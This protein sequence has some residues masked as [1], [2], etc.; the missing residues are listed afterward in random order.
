MKLLNGILKCTII[1]VFTSLLSCNGGIGGKK[2]KVGFLIR[3]FVIDRCAIERDFFVERMNQL[4]GEAIIA[5][6]GE[7][8]KIQVGQGRELLDKDIDVLVIFPVNNSSSAEIVRAANAK[9]VPVIAYE[10]LIENCNLDYFISAD[11]KKAGNIMAQHLVNQ[12][13][14]GNYVIIGGDRFDKNAISIKEGNY[15]VINPLIKSGNINVMYDIFSNWTADDAYIEIK[16][17]LDLTGTNPDAILCSN[18]GM[19]RGIIKA[20]DEYGL[21]GKIPVTGLDADLSAC[22]YIAQGKQFL[23]IYKSFKQ[24]AYTATEMAY[25]IAQGH[26]PKQLNAEV[27]NGRVNVA[28]YLIT[29][30]VVDKNNLKEIIIDNKV[31]SADQVY[32]N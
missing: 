21:A 25:E 22:R 3:G 23:T 28:S 27:F 17:V 32:G 2:V 1:I 18:D 29:P 19:A 26:K 13:P 7:N 4:G 6:A 30:V 12:V 31:F 14:K 9:K 15:Q 24:Q 20:L 5:D 8:E 10:S 11:N 16:K